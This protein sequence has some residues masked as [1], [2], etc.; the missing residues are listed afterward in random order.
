[1]TKSQKKTTS[2]SKSIHVSKPDFKFKISIRFWPYYTH[3][4]TAYITMSFNIRRSLVLYYYKIR[5]TQERCKTGSHPCCRSDLYRVDV[6]GWS[7]G[8]LDDRVA[9]RCH[10]ADGGTYRQVGHAHPHLSAAAESSPAPPRVHLCHQHWAGLRQ[11]PVGVSG[12]TLRVFKLL[13]FSNK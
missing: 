8:V 6:T 2:I 9:L 10:P 4:I 7:Q 1:M 3:Q 11:R 12:K 13:C 5:Q